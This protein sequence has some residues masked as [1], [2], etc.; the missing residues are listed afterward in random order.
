MKSKYSLLL[1]I[2]I[3]FTA[4]QWPPIVSYA[5][6]GTSPIR[7][8]E[9]TP[10]EASRATPSEAD[11]IEDD[12][13]F[14][15]EYSSPSEAQRSV[16][17]LVDIDID[18]IA[19][20]F[21][22]N[23]IQKGAGQFS[24]D[25]NTVWY[26]NYV[27]DT[28]D[29]SYAYEVL[30]Q[31]GD[32]ID[33][34]WW[35]YWWDESLDGWH[36]QAK[37]TQ[38]SFDGEN[39][40]YF[41]LDDNGVLTTQIPALINGLPVVSMDDCFSSWSMPLTDPG[42]LP[43]TIISAARCYKGSE[44]TAMP[45][46]P[47]GLVNMNYM[48]AD[49]QELVDMTPIPA[50][51]KQ[52]DYAF[53]SSGIKETP[54]FLP[55]SIIQELNHTFDN[56]QQLQTV[57]NLPNVVERLEATFWCAFDGADLRD[58]YIPDTVTEMQDTFFRSGIQ[59]APHFPPN[60]KNIDRCF[61]S[62]TQLLD[63]P[64]M[65]DSIESA[66]RAFAYCSSL[67]FGDAD[68]IYVIAPKGL[69]NAQNMFYHA[70]H[71]AG[72]V[73]HYGRDSELL[74]LWNEE[75]WEAINQSAYHTGL[76]DTFRD[77]HGDYILSVQPVG[78][79]AMELLS[80][81]PYIDTGLTINEGKRAIE[82]TFRG[83]M[84]E[85]GVAPDYYP[86]DVI[87]YRLGGSGDFKDWDG[88][89]LY[90]YE[91]TLLEARK[92]RRVKTY[93]GM[94]EI[95]T[96][97][98]TKQV[99][100]QQPDTP[101]FSYAYKGGGIYDVTIMYRPYLRSISHVELKYKVNDGEWMDIA[102]LGHIT[103]HCEDTIYAY[104]D[105]GAASEITM[106]RLPDYVK[107]IEVVNPSTY[108]GLNDKIPI[109]CN[110]F[111]E[112][113]G[114]R[115]YQVSIKENSSGILELQNDETGWNIRNTGY[116]EATIQVSASDGSGV[117]AEKT[118]NFTS[119]VQSINLALEKNADNILDIGETDK[120]LVT[121]M[122]SH[123]KG[124]VLS[125]TNP[126]ILALDSTTGTITGIHAGY[127]KLTAT[128]TV[129]PTISDSLDIQVLGDPYAVS[130]SPLSA[131][132]YSDETLLLN[133]NW[134]PYQVTDPLYKQDGVPVKLQVID[135]GQGWNRIQVTAQ[136]NK[137]TGKTNISLSAHSTPSV[138]DTC[139]ITWKP[140][141]HE[142]ALQGP[143]Q[144]P[145]GNHAETSVKTDV[146]S[147]ESLIYTSS[148]SD[149]L[150][151]DQNGKLY[152]KKEGEA[153]IT[154]TAS[155]G[156]ATDGII[157]QVIEPENRD[158]TGIKLSV[159]KDVLT[160][161]ESCN[162]QVITEPAYTSGRYDVVSTDTSILSVENGTVKANAPGLVVLYA[163]ETEDPEGNPAARDEVSVMVVPNN[164]ALLKIY[165][166]TKLW[167]RDGKPIVYKNL[168][169]GS[170][171]QFGHE[172]ITDSIDRTITWN[173]DQPD[174]ASIDENGVLTPKHNG[175]VVVTANS[176]SYP[177]V[178][179][180]Y[181]MEIR[182]VVTDIKYTA[183][184]QSNYQYIL[185]AQKYPDD[186][187]PEK[188]YGRLN[189]NADS[190]Y[191]EITAQGFPCS[192]GSVELSTCT[193]S[194]SIEDYSKTVHLNYG[195]S[196]GRYELRSMHDDMPYTI[197]VTD[198]DANNQFELRI[199]DTQQNR[200]LSTGDRTGIHWISSFLP[201]SQ[202]LLNVWDIGI[203]KEQNGILQL[204]V[205]T[206][207]TLNA[208]DMN[209]DI[210]FISE[211]F[212]DQKLAVKTYHII[213]D[214]QDPTEISLKCLDQSG[215]ERY[216]YDLSL[217]TDD[218]PEFHN[219]G[220]GNVALNQEQGVAFLDINGE[221][222]VSLEAC[223]RRY[224]ISIYLGQENVTSHVLQ[225]V[226]QKGQP[227]VELSRE[228]NYTINVMDR[229]NHIGTQ[230]QLTAINETDFLNM[231]IAQSNM[232][233]NNINV[234]Q[235]NSD[236]RVYAIPVANDGLICLDD[237]NYDIDYELLPDSDGVTRALY[238]DHLIMAKGYTQDTPFIVENI[239]ATVR[240]ADN[241]IAY[242]Y[243]SYKAYNQMPSI[244]LPSSVD[245]ES[246]TE[247]EIPLQFMPYY[248]AKNILLDDLKSGLI[249]LELNGQVVTDPGV[250]GNFTIT[251]V[252]DGALGIICR[253]DQAETAKLFAYIDGSVAEQLTGDSSN[254]GKQLGQSSCNLKSQGSVYASI[255]DM[256]INILDEEELNINCGLGS[257][258]ANGRVTSY[259][260]LNAPDGSTPLKCD[261][262]KV[263]ALEAGTWLVSANV[264]F[265][266][267]GIRNIL[268]QF[269]VTIKN[270][271]NILTITER[272]YRNVCN[273]GESL[274]LVPSYSPLD[275]D[276][277]DGYIWSI[278]GGAGAQI[279]QNGV[280]TTQRA[281][282]YTA[283]LQD[284]PNKSLTAEYAF[285]VIDPPVQITEIR[286][287]PQ[288][289]NIT[290]SESIKYNAELLP[291]NADE[292]AVIWD[293]IDANHRAIIDQAGEFHGL[294]AGDYTV[295]C[296]LASNSEIFDTATVHVSVLPE[297]LR[298]DGLNCA[299]PNTVIQLS[300]IVFPEDAAYT[301]ISWE[302]TSGSDYATISSAG[303]VSCGSEAGIIS[304]K[305]TIDG[306][307]ISA[308]HEIVIGQVLPKLYV[309][310]LDD[311]GEPKNEI[312]HSSDPAYLYIDK[313]RATKSYVNA[314]QYQI[315]LIPN[316]VGLAIDSSGAVHG[317]Q[318]G[319]Y[320]INVSRQV[321]GVTIQDAAPIAVLQVA[322]Y[323]YLTVWP[324]D[325][326][327][328][329]TS[330]G[331]SKELEYKLTPDLESSD[332]AVW[333]IQSGNDIAVID[334]QGHLTAN[335][336]K[337][338]PVT[339]QC[340]IVDADGNEIISQN[341]TIMVSGQIVPVSSIKINCKT[342]LVVG[343]QAPITVT[344]LPS[345]ANNQEYNITVS[346]LTV[347]TVESNIFLA[348]KPGTV[349]LTATPLDNPSCSDSITIYV[350]AAQSPD[351]KPA[352]EPRPDPDSQHAHSTINSQSTT[353]I[354]TYWYLRDNNWYYYS[355]DGQMVKNNWVLYRNQWY[356]LGAD[357]IML[358][359]QWYEENGLQYYLSD[360][361][362][363]VS[364][365]W[366]YVDGGWLYFDS[367]GTPTQNTAHDGFRLVDQELIY[368][369]LSKGNFIDV[370]IYTYYVDDRKRV[371][372]GCWVE[373]NNAWYYSGN[374]GWILKDQWN[375]VDNKWYF[376]NPDGRL[377]MVSTIWEGDLYQMDQYGVAHNTSK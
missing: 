149:I 294:R 55:D 34:T 280:V 317:L 153:T 291:E 99:S 274:Y 54:E 107:R 168:P 240:Q 128:S 225:R 342:Q 88:T 8:S 166:E 115:T 376:M 101:Q 270:P 345:N 269:K 42:E 252:K 124:Y 224:N 92:L 63:I 45:E 36:I 277:V 357:G 363:M 278:K 329:I 211:N 113:A 257:T 130:L 230:R 344:I 97:V 212:N 190:T 339:V 311:S 93:N 125:V 100:V 170:Q 68:N 222:F 299:E 194:P 60:V 89:I 249:K 308:E 163:Q 258:A 32:Q 175:I 364:S 234:F 145:A 279:D 352:P 338:G 366:A 226:N 327:Y 6:E 254:R 356:Q 205:G 319:D 181:Q 5:D 127:T 233:E 119:N 129:D 227:C 62:C 162:Y 289:A 109:V 314:N 312:Y 133:G 11:F 371:Q 315:D 131:E 333:S 292:Q 28:N 343:D 218:I 196:D 77:A 335:G 9:A 123:Q 44:I 263:Q 82:V 75:Q 351:S 192:M 223:L 180:S 214:Q 358:N 369:G 182:T 103:A 183:V 246:G 217:Y 195:Q 260:I 259:E 321:A 142:I 111:E 96:D 135:G 359:N 48:F 151:V 73:D 58:L 245:M 347:G 332:Q 1:A 256:I 53:A 219:T 148:N 355:P 12:V 146:V 155:H 283:I 23:P 316:R 187:S 39:Y 204:K 305:A 370:G 31:S 261:A 173:V 159:E 26:L 49:C 288:N 178:V 307:N 303:Q 152:A 361:G 19:L 326:D 66:E 300:G 199:Y 43:S 69:I 341:C 137:A 188:I 273:T 313:H 37:P 141:I 367:N 2:T 221:A 21:I 354:T 87:Q 136:N 286:I 324:K 154:V 81:A 174:L 143:A 309:E 348:Q 353:E 242:V 13:L 235:G 349:L 206:E 3:F 325:G 301:G 239:K 160:V 95:I 165:P 24:L 250:Y 296:Y 46:L 50:L 328:R 322:R 203:L 134:Q 276:N 108:I 201:K 179:A 210:P 340:S 35:N 176:N 156:G 122:P 285:Q 98:R 85:Y 83:V 298:I 17:E 372:A 208:L 251:Y 237:S 79:S 374:T 228:G 330:R 38:Y 121:I 334:Q 84:G 10:A 138:F 304:I 287:T 150:Q 56:C 267:H 104:A 244:A 318:A 290:N 255:K 293:V 41:L 231:Y 243:G 110:I 114:D 139:K 177:D 64:L 197:F 76:N 144:I 266:L 70:Y 112:T 169:G 323:T 20:F 147:D 158:I 59:I 140:Y 94:E 161:G 29:K 172:I 216:T 271:A 105:W 247:Y 193:G 232:Q 346:D 229:E 71:T 18:E 4:I 375:E 16:D 25:G 86:N 253:S 27:K 30:D 281:G 33:Q 117:T 198:L 360:N 373:N 7:L 275:A 337:N 164:S 368:T 116:G 184:K 213:S 74:Y 126:S 302:I 106:L 65:P 67:Q 236:V 91:D 350:V 14:D 209:C 157:I 191:E 78:L 362:S 171:I 22:E 377:E 268:C 72:Q 365:S 284:L 262:T 80:T 336:T 306:T 15:T 200:Y 310:I 282:Y 52:M 189:I 40:S 207:L 57:R 241:I 220:V 120:A 331:G 185:T 320:A 264:Q 47:D 167:E 248:G 272:N 90:L 295:K 238:S 61:E 202:S 102:N 118:F 297:F 132:L 265:N 186:A 215:N 51:V